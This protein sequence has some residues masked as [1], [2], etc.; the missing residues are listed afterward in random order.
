[1]PWDDTARKQHSRDGAALW[2]VRRRRRHRGWRVGPLPLCA[3]A[4]A[5][6]GNGSGTGFRL[7]G[8]ETADYAVNDIDG[9]TGPARFPHSS[10]FT[11]RSRGR[12][13]PLVGRGL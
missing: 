13:P 4:M 7:L 2:L 1:M 10:V 8:D 12:S 5:G 3:V 6:T 11:T 9:T